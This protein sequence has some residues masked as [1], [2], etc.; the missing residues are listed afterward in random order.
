MSKLL[1]DQLPD[2]FQSGGQ[3]HKGTYD[4]NIPAQPARKYQS[5]KKTFFQ[6]LFPLG[7]VSYLI[8]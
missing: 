8:C 4:G 6:L 1:F 2:I 3:V 7:F 5:W